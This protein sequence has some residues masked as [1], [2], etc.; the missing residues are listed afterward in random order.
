[1][2]TTTIGLLSVNSFSR[3]PVT[4]EPSDM[5]EEWGIVRKEKEEKV[6]EDCRV[7]QEDVM[8]QLM[9]METRVRRIRSYTVAWVRR[10]GLLLCWRRQLPQQPDLVGETQ[11]RNRL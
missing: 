6:T 2:L 11:F 9:N 7:D 10:V 4:T 5:E 1:M 3:R 8:D